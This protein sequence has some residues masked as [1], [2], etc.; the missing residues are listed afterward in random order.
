M[1]HQYHVELSNGKSYTVT[2]TEHHENHTREV[3]LKHLADIISRTASGVAS[4]MIVR[5]LYKGSK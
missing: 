5:Y 3:F 2:T 4:A 1:A